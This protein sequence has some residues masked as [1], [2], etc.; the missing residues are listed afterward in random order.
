MQP[1]RLTEMM[2]EETYK[3]IRE[4]SVLVF[5]AVNAWTDSQKREISLLAVLLFAAGGLFWSLQSGRSI[6]H[7]LIP[8]G[9]GMV[10]LVLAVLT[11]GAVGMGDAWVLLDLGIVLET[12]EFLI[13]VCLG[14]LL[15]GGCAMILLAL[16][17]AGRRT[18]IP[19]VPFL[20][21]GYVGGLLLY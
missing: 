12:G 15:S 5:L 14:V 3:M 21:A 9:T 10:V 2:K 11:R 13:T 6:F 16:K 17:K 8:L 7:A 20:L 4:V 18:E 1:L 19:F